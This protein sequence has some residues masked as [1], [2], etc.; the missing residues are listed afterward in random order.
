MNDELMMALDDLSKLIAKEIKKINTKADLTA[1]EIKNATDAVCLLIKIQELQNGD[2]DWEDEGQS[3]RSY[4]HGMSRNSYRRGRNARTGRYMSYD[5]GYSGH[6]VHDRMI[7]ALEGL[8][9][10]AESDYDRGVISDGIRMI[11]QYER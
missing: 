11:R 9:D 1:T 10:R 6:S 2:E 3:E 5:N 4:R 7:A 8:M